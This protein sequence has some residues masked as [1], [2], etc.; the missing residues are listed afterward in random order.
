MF[1]NCN[2]STFLDLLN[3]DKVASS[4]ADRRFA[5]TSC[6]KR[7]TT[8]SNVNA[9]TKTVH[10]KHEKENTNST[11]NLKDATIEHK[12]CVC[13]KSNTGK[14]CLQAQQQMMREIVQVDPRH[15]PYNVVVQRREK[16][17]QSILEKH[18]DAT[19][20]KLACG[21]TDIT[22]EM[23]HAEIKEWSCYKEAIGQ[24]ICYNAFDPRH[25]LRVYLF[26]RY[27]IKTKEMALMV[28]N[29]QNIRPFEF[30]EV[31]SKI[32]VVDMLTGEREF[33]TEV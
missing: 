17:F 11:V 33:I 30:E 6:G 21:E 23:F 18:F 28:F 32:N 7:F 29:Q 24:L 15:V 26:G 16:F 27:G 10:K 13:D 9:H 5:C 19:H 8:K 20:K 14:I 25:D 3:K 1:S 2:G 4:G 12:A 31:D 22:T